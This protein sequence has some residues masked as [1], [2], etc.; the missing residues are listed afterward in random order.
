MT[1][2]AGRLGIGTS[3]PRAMLDVRGSFRA[4]GTIIQVQSTTRTS[5]DRYAFSNT[6]WAD[7]S[8]M[9][10]SITPKFSTSA[11]L[12]SWTLHVGSNGHHHFRLAKNDTPLYGALGTLAGG[13]RRTISGI[14]S[15]GN[16]YPW[17]GIN[18]PITGEY[19][20]R[21]IQSGDSSR[22]NLTYKLQ[23]ISGNGST[24]YT[25]AINRAY[26]QQDDAN[27]TSS[28]SEP[29]YSVASSTITVKEISM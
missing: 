5:Y 20:D 7:I 3:E 17:Y 22:G 26:E 6:A 27:L 12:V 4:P 25:L 23:H 8:G 15:D 28:G 10:V 29:Y 9:A 18:Y 13:R 24:S 19:L 2:K 1:L 14:A 11:I 16:T 21:G